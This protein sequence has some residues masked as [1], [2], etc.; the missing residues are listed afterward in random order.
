MKKLCAFL[1]LTAFPAF[2]AVNCNQPN[3]EYLNDS[4]VCLSSEFKEMNN[5]IQ[6][7]EDRLRVPPENLNRELSLLTEKLAREIGDDEASAAARAALQKQMDELKY[8]LQQAENDAAEEKA[9][10]V[11]IRDRGRSCRTE[12]CMAEVYAQT[13]AGLIYFSRREEC[14]LPTVPEDC[15]IYVDNAPNAKNISTGLLLSE[16]KETYVEEVLVNR[17]GKCVYLFL[18]SAN[19]QIWEIKATEGTD[20]KEIYAGGD[21]PQLVRGFADGTKTVVHYGEELLKTAGNC[22]RGHAGGK[23]AESFLQK[24]KIDAGR[25]KYAA[26][27]II[28]DKALPQSYLYFPENSTGTPTA[29]V[30]PPDDAG[31]Q[32]LLNEGKVRRVTETDVERF[33]KA[34]VVNL[35]NDKFLWR[36]DDYRDFFAAA[37]DLLANGYILLKDVDRLPEGDRKAFVFVDAG[38]RLPANIRLDAAA[39]GEVSGVGDFSRSFLMLPAEEQSLPPTIN[40]N[41]PEGIL[42]KVVCANAPLRAKNLQFRRLLDERRGEMPEMINAYQAYTLF[43]LRGCRTKACAGE[44]LDNAVRWLSDRRYHEETELAKPALCRLK[45]ISPECEVYAYSTYQPEKES[46]NAALSENGRTFNAEVRVNQPGKCV[47]LFLSAHEPTVW[48][49]Y[50]TPATD[51]EAV[52][53]GGSGPQ[54]LRGMK[55]EVQTRVRYEGVDFEEGD[56]CLTGYLERENM[57]T[58]VRG[59]NIGIGNVKLLDEPVVGEKAEDMFYEYDGESA[60]GAKPLPAAVKKEAE[61]E[62]SQTPQVDAAAAPAAATAGESTLENKS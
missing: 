59:L 13:L 27:G 34:G 62:K 16:Q 19:P 58:A 38:Q 18:T 60:A 41:R 22:L 11:R 43:R 24:A 14:A 28:G 51:L 50:T 2:A 31:W 25:I 56:A 39:G 54:M 61:K 8:R 12:K 32:R 5:Q 42:A 6:E 17:P 4:Y 30:L 55:P 29:A 21:H 53:V 47:I 52:V 33:K 1:V 40:C 7:I 48:D 35:D 3:L 10:I 49:I 46:G 36:R 15:E 44:V 57:E 37:D 45:D 26:G 23:A 9:F 20:I